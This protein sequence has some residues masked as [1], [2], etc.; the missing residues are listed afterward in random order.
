MAAWYKILLIAWFLTV[1]PVA[2]LAYGFS[3]DRFVFPDVSAF[4]LAEIVNFVVMSAWA[5]SPLLLAPW[6]WRRTGNTTE[7][8]N[9]GDST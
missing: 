1:V 8:R 3:G 7:L 2:L 4:G 5:L 6:G 9:Y